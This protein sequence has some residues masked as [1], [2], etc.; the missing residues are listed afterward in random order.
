ML[1]YLHCQGSG[2]LF[3]SPSLSTTRREYADVWAGRTAQREG[4]SNKIINKQELWG[5]SCHSN[6]CHLTSGGLWRAGMIDLPFSVLQLFTHQQQKFQLKCWSGGIFI[7]TDT[8]EAHVSLQAWMSWW[9]RLGEERGGSEVNESPVPLA[10]HILSL[11]SA[12]PPQAFTLRYN[13]FRLIWSLAGNIEQNMRSKEVEG[14][15]CVRVFVSI[16]TATTW[17]GEDGGWRTPKLIT[18]SCAV[19][20][21]SDVTGQCWECRGGSVRALT[22]QSCWIST[23]CWETKLSM[24]CEWQKPQ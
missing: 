7:A 24:N 14:C 21:R 4:W 16:F 3:L 5:F 10:A 17:L 15:G 8:L 20:A 19:S 1:A 18:D 2:S 12:Q 9:R 11:F 22:P 23:E 13:T 6:C